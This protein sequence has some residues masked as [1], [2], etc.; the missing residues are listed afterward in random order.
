MSLKAAAEMRSSCML[1]NSAASS[2][3]FKLQQFVVLLIISNVANVF[4]HLKFD[5]QAV[6]QVFNYELTA[7]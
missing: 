2:D 3:S 7:M 5:A 1:N 6:R 4:L